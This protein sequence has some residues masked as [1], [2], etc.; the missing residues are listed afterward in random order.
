M[1]WNDWP[2]GATVTNTSYWGDQSYQN[3]GG[4]IY[5]I[6]PL[7]YDTIGYGFGGNRSPSQAVLP[8]TIVSVGNGT[9]AFY[10]I[11]WSAELGLFCA[12]TNIGTGNRITVSSDGFIWQNTDASPDLIYS[13]V[14]WCKELGLFVALAE[15]PGATN[16]VTSTDGYTWTA[17]T[18]PSGY[19][20]ALCWSPELRLFCAIAHFAFSTQNVMTSPDG[21][22]WTLRTSS[23]SSDFK[24]IC[25]S[26]EVKLFATIG[27]SGSGNRLMT[28]PDGVTWTTRSVPDQDYTW[29]TWVPSINIFIGSSN[30][31]SSTVY[32][33]DGI[34]W[35]LA[36]L[37]PTQQSRWV[38]FQGCIM[39]LAGNTRSIDGTTWYPQYS[40]AGSGY[41]ACVAPELNRIVRAGYGTV[42]ISL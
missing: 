15:S 23:S 41:S 10:S 6:T 2:L 42:G 16:V 38:P 40:G 17:R 31:N 8:T 27:N 24:A 1:Q 19:W 5:S 12:V 30:G 34:T 20:K 14:V 25:W 13:D 39:S 37:T 36:S 32:S 9:Q 4:S 26:P 35:T 29:I 11:A 21:I 22:T 18:T 33:Y 28:S 3:P 7:S